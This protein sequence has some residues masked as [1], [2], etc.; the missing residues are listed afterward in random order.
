[1]RQKM[2]KKPPP[3]RTLRSD[4][5]SKILSSIFSG[6]LPG[7]GRLIEEEVAEKLGVSRT[8]VREALGELASIGVIQLRPNHGAMVRPFGPAQLI[9]IYHVRRILEVEAT[10]MAGDH[11]DPQA[12]TDIR[13]QTQELLAQDDRSPSWTETALALDQSF[14]ELLSR[15]SGS[16]RLAEEIGKYRNLV[17]AVGDAVGN[18][19]HA[20]DQNMSE[21]TAIIDHLLS[22]RA[23]EAAAAMGRHIDRGA[24][25]AAEWL[26]LVYEGREPAATALA[27]SGKS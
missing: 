10:R 20:H 2:L 13:E 4:L 19:L 5:V 16:E 24:N 14:H 9:E 12:L 26:R 22:R 25:T 27:R 15:S 6:E 7:G 8:P 21:H 3:R 18:K 11:I 1:M 17:V 23:N